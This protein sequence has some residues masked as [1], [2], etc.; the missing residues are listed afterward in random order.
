VLVKVAE[1]T[2]LEP[3]FLTANNTVYSWT[4]LDLS[5]RVLQQPDT[6]ARFGFADDLARVIDAPGPS[7]GR[8]RFHSGETMFWLAVWLRFK[9]ASARRRITSCMANRS[10]QDLGMASAP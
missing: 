10:S 8:D 3:A 6:I 7:I 1:L 2:G 9:S 5:K 4:W